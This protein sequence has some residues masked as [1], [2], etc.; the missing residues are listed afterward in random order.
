MFEL[1]SSW[2]GLIVSLVLGAAVGSFANVIIYR[3]PR[4][5]LSSFRPA[6]SFCPSCRAQ[7]AWSDN[8]P[9]LS[10]LVLKGRCRSC[11][12]RISWRYPLVELLMAALFGVAW[13]VF[14][15]G[16]AD[17][18]TRLLVA[19]YLV[20]ACVVVAVIDWE[21]QII[22]DTITWPGMVL[23]V[24]ASLAFPVLHAG[25]VGFR[26]QAPHASSL[27]AS[28]IGLAIGGGSLALVGVLGNLFLRRKLES[29]G[30]QDSMGWG[31]VKWMAL[32]GS[33][34]G[35]LQVMSAILLACFV[36]ATVG[37]V[38]IA[39]ARLRGRDAP[40]GLPFGPFLALGMLV[41]LVS[42]GLAWG[43]LGQITGHAA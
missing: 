43:L 30:L 12:V 11:G 40:V 28:L 34:L 31:D 1:A 26:E 2:A 24:V 33:F 42:P 37:L 17:M 41:E 3:S 15:P 32:A 13:W 8:L 4:E 38:L 25:H 10:W 27:M 14:H 6:R 23:G 29:A 18:L 5:G 20:A 36:G 19:W 21:H 22:P 35:A 7:L 9:V 16:D 39:A